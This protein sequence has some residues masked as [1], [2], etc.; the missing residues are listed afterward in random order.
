[1]WKKEKKVR[2]LKLL[3]VDN[4]V[5]CQAI[6]REIYGLMNLSLQH[7]LVNA[8]ILLF[9]KAENWTDVGTI[10]TDLQSH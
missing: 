8:S 3:K 6:C 7:A 10:D 9:Y 5:P 1:M 4:T 2:I